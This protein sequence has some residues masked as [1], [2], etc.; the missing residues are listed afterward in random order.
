MK[1]TVKSKISF[2]G[3]V[4]AMFMSIVDS[5]VINVTIP[6]IQNFFH[7]TLV[8]ASWTSTSYLLL[9]TTFML[10]S[11]KLADQYGRKKLILIGIT[12][13]GTFSLL[14]AL[15]PTL[16]KLIFFRFFQ[17][18]GGAIIT[19][20]I[21]PIGVNIFGKEK[22]SFIA[23]VGGAISALAAA[24]GPLIG[25]I[26]L[27]Y[28]D[29]RYI[30]IINIPFSI[31]SFLI[32]FSF[33]QESFDETAST[34]LDLPGMITLFLSLILIVFSLLK[35]NDYGYKSPIISISFLLGIIFLIIYFLIEI[36]SKHPMFDFKLFRE[37][38]FAN[39][40]LVYL[41]TGFSLVCP[42]LILN[43]FLQDLLKYSALKSSLITTT[44]S[45]TIIFSMPLGSKIAN[46]FSAN[47]T[48]TLGLIF[49]SISLFL[50][51]K[52]SFNTSTTKI[53][54]ILII[55]G[56]GFGFTSQSIISSVKYIPI[57]KNGLASGMIN[58]LRQ[59]GTC[60]GVAILITILNSNIQV[61]KK[62]IRHSYHYETQKILTNNSFKKYSNN[63]S[64]QT[65][66]L[67]NQKYRNKLIFVAKKEILQNKLKQITH[68]KITLAFSKTYLI[69]STIILISVPFG[70][71]TD[72]EKS[73]KKY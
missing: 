20:L 68:K 59:L 57:S 54:Y 37:K 6:S 1:T 65:K 4:V 48:N 73:F 56:L 17:G 66:Q 43:F 64:N 23:S 69:C 12:I 72:K 5:T 62:N 38:T 45:F 26:I 15:S 53:I 13:F 41:M 39:S 42:T 35:S 3:L 58:T 19:P 27:H 50:L 7:A 51:S 34:K 36:N 40:C 46:K 60:L 28:Y 55:N 18:I 31:I 8:N 67:Q 10:I 52:V 11:S 16:N 29:C 25:G 47:I 22:L 21:L 33:I 24:G 63:K 30:F 70:L 9:L 14:S 49:I 32:I 71:S 61:A 44:V 2:I